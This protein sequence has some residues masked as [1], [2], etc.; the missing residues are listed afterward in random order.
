[1]SWPLGRR[2]RRARLF[3]RLDSIMPWDD[4]VLMLEPACPI[5]STGRRPY[6]LKTMV[7][8]YVLQWLFALSDESVE[9]MI[10]DS[11]SAATFVGIDPWKPRPPG[12]SAIGRFRK[13][14]EEYP[15]DEF[16]LALHLVIVAARAEIRM[17]RII[18]PV[19]KIKPGGSITE[20]S[21]CRP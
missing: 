10:L 12:E 19:L 6:P 1:V 8:V 17:G 11:H 21:Q 20:G 13:L 9:D 15:N 3:E 18:E 2:P 5:Q 16:R 14:V 7:R 4:L